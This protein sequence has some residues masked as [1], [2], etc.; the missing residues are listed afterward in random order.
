M[1]LL[2]V[3]DDEEEG[4]HLEQLKDRLDGVKGEGEV[5]LVGAVE[6]DGEPLTSHVYEAG[7]ALPSEIRVEHADELD[8]PTP[9]GLYEQRRLEAG[10][11]REERPDAREDGEQV[12]DQQPCA[13]LPCDLRLLRHHVA[14][15]I[16]AE[17][18]AEA[19]DD[20]QSPAPQQYM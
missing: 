17:G 8:H 13:V 18:R 15:D 16:V 4:R 2:T 14:S 20:V 12:D 5:V 6:P 7:D 9:A 11:S 10:A 3:H 1:G 19:D